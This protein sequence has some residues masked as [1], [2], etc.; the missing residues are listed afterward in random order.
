MEDFIGRVIIKF[1][2]KWLEVDHENNTLR[3][4]TPGIVDE[5]LTV[6]GDV[7][8]HSELNVSSNLT[9]LG[10]ADFEKDVV[11]KGGFVEVNDTRQ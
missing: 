11:V 8:A 5:N 10:T 3:F 7:S 9:V 6:N 4:R 2:S 1:L